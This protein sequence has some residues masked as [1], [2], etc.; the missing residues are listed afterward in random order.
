QVSSVH[1]LPSSHTGGVPPKQA[2][3]D[4]SQLSKPLHASPSSHGTIV[5]VHTPFTQVS[6]LVQALPSSQATVALTKCM[7]P[8]GETQLS[9]VHGFPS[10][11]VGGVPG[12]Q[13]PVDGSQVSSP[14]Q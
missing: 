9:S 10:S 5:P 6:P 7:Q 3:V 11:H 2:P 14:L 1:G 4:G 8:V 13:A 12:R